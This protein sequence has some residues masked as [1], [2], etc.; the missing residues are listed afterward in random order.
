M[1]GFTGE[2]SS[3]CLQGSGNYDDDM[4]ITNGMNQYVCVHD[5]SMGISE[6]S[7]DGYLEPWDE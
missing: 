5:F 2:L 1:D 7:I 3:L 4:L 6:E